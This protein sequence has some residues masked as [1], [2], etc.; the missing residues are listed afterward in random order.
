[1]GQGGP[2][3]RHQAGVR[4]AN[5][6]VMHHLPQRP[7]QSRGDAL[8]SRSC[9]MNAVTLQH[10]GPGRRHDQ[11]VG[12]DHPDAACGKLAANGGDIGRM[13]RGRN[14][15]GA[16]VQHEDAEDDDFGAG[17]YRAVG[18]CE[19]L[20]GGL[21]TDAGVDHAPRNAWPAAWPGAGTETIPRAAVHIR[22]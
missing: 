5:Q 9:Q 13:L 20:R 15:V 10:S 3:R 14:A 8:I 1:M 22:R 12:I 21:P 6:L 18:A 7:H 11:A 2:R 4:A 16:I 17:G 19:D